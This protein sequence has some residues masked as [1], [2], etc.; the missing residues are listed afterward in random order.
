MNMNNDAHGTLLAADTIRLQR[1]LPGPVERVWRYLTEP[2]LRRQWLAG[3][4]F[5]AP[6]DRHELV[7]RNNSLTENDE[8]A[9]AKYA[10]MADEVR[11]HGRVVECTPHER[12]VITWNENDE[13]VGSEVAFELQPRGSEVELTLT[14]S[15][16]PSRD[17]ML[18]VAG[19]WHA[20]L[21]V[22][23][24]RLR[25]ETPPGLWASFNQLEAEYDRLIPQAT[26]PAAA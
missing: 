10:D 8:P 12:L 21:R 24:A 23:I 6:G 4:A 2:E 1:T 7:F 9:P 5:G 20:H 13:G 26:D 3:G 14:H 15:R 17:S 11:I 19:G 25:D 22:L 18:S 16:L